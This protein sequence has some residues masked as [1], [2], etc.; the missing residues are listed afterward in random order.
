M[1]TLKERV[2]QGKTFIRNCAIP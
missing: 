1:L 2:A